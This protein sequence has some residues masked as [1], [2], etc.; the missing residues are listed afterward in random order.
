MY[1]S[2]AP[3]NGCGSFLQTKTLEIQAMEKLLMSRQILTFFEW[4]SFRKWTTLAGESPT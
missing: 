4:G 2:P 3:G 1:G